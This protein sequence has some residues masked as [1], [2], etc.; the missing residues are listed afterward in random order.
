LFWQEIGFGLTL[1]ARHHLP[2]NILGFF[3]GKKK[4]QIFS[5]AAATETSLALKLF[6]KLGK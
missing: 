2:A 5:P 1:A 4:H 3:G 6:L